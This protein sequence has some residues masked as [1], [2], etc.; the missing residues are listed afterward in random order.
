M[1]DNNLGHGF[2]LVLNLLN[3]KSLPVVKDA[4]EK[5]YGIHCPHAFTVWTFNR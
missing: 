1:L 3:Q 2:Q 4:G 5:G